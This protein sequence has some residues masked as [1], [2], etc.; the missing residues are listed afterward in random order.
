MMELPK[1]VYYILA[2][3]A[4]VFVGNLL[5]L[6]FFIVSQ[7][8]TLLD[9]QTRLSQIA[10]R[11]PNTVI[12]KTTETTPTVIPDSSCPVSC[13]AMIT[14]STRSATIKQVL[15]PTVS[16]P[17]LPTPTISQKGEYFISLGTGSVLNSEASNSN[18]KTIDTAQVTFDAASYGNIKSA[19]L[20]V[21]LHVLGGG[22]VHARL[23]DTTTPNVFWGT[24]LSTSSSNSTYL[25]GPLTLSS[26]SKTY[27]IQMYST[28]STGYLDQARIH[29][30]T[31]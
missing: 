27:K 30:V 26:G 20:E 17:P 28:L 14:N 29:I 25:S 1:Y 31:Q 3:L 8:G 10:N 6:D 16:L 9:F 18:W 21:F 19:T 13:I 12:Q 23:F 22:E 4:L 2:F 15:N 5:L 7:N 24:D 11:S